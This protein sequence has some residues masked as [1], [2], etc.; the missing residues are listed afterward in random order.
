MT[1][2]WMQDHGDAKRI[3]LLS[4]YLLVVILCGHLGLPAKGE[5]AESSIGIIRASNLNMRPAAN[6]QQ[7][8]LMIE[9]M[10]S[11]DEFDRSRAFLFE[12]GKQIGVN[13]G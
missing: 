2:Y 3:K 9:H 10:Q 12:T 1:S 11:A 7:P 4:F 8:P 5:G 13:F 6:T